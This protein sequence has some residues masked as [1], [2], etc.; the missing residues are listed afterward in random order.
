MNELPF[1][2]EEKRTFVDVLAISG[3]AD[4]GG[5]ALHERGLV[6]VFG[7]WRVGAAVRPDGLLVL[8]PVVS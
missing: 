5:V 7:S 1:T 6:D 8:A 3:T 4:W 2:I